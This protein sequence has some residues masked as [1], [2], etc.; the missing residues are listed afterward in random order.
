MDKQRI[1]TAANSIDGVKSATWNEYTRVL[2]LKYDVFKKEAA[3][4]V[5]KKIALAGNDTEKYRAEDAAYQNLP[6]CCHY[7]RKPL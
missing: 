7:K 1:E 5:Q 6:D 4:D 2:T 3:D